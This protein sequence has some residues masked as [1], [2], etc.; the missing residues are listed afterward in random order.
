MVLI[1]RVAGHRA[2]LSE[3][4]IVRKTAGKGIECEEKESQ[5]HVQRHWEAG[6]DARLKLSPPLRGWVSVS[7]FEN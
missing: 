4:S 7:T 5:L 1:P 6:R 2:T 3:D